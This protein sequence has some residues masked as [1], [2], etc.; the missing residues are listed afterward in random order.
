MAL[1]VASGPDMPW[2]CVAEAMGEEMPQ[3]LLPFADVAM[4]RFFQELFLSYEEIARLQR[5]V[6]LPAEVSA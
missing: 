5:D 6:V 3:E 2:L 1:T 4:V